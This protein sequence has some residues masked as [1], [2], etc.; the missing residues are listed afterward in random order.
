MALTTGARLGPYEVTPLLGAGGMGEVWRARDTRLNRDVALKFLLEVFLRDPERMARFEREAQLLA[1]LNHPNIAQ[2]YGLE[3]SG[4]ARA[5]VMEYVPGQILQG[6]LPVEEALPIAR[7]IAEALEYAHDRGIIHRDL[8]PS[9][10]KLTPEGN[11]KVLDFGLAKALDD[12]PSEGGLHNSPTLSV[13]GTRAG[14]ILGT[15]AYMSPE[16]AKGKPVD[17]RADIWS[18]GAVI[19]EILTGRQ[20]Y[21]G[22]TAAETLAAV[23]MKDP[24]LERLPAATPPAV[25]AMIRRCLEKDPRKRLQAIGEARL[26]LEDPPAQPLAP[27]PALT[28]PRPSGS[29]RLAWALGAAATLAAAALAFVHFRET[30]AETPPVR[31]QIS[32]PEKT[33]FRLIPS[34]SPDGRRV[35]FSAT[36]EGG[37]TRLWVRPLG[38]LE[39]QPLPGTDDAGY[40]FW[41]PDSRFI[42]FSAQGKL[43]KV[44]VSGGP[45]QTLCDAPPLVSGAWSRQGVIVFGSTRV[46]LFRVAAAGGAATPLTTLDPSR[47]EEGHHEPFFLPDDRHFLYFI[48]ARAAE[49]SGVYLGAVDARADSKDRRRLLG[50][51]SHAEYAPP[52]DGRLGHLLFVRE[53]TLMAQP[54]DARK[55]Q[56][57]GEPFP[58]AERVRAFVGHGSFSVSDTGVLAWREGASGLRAQLTWFDREGKKL[59]TAGKPGYYNNVA[60]SPDGRQAA[61]EHSP[62]ADRN[63]DIWL[64]DLIR[65]IPSRFTFHA[66]I[67]RLPV[68]SPDGGRIVFGSGRDGPLNL[69]EKTSNG[70]GNETALLQSNTAKYPHDWSRDGRFLVYS[71]QDPKTRLDL[72]VLP[73]TGDR[74]PA[75]YLQT[76]FDETQGQFSPD[77]KWMAYVSTESGV[78][79]V[80]VQ[81][82]PAAGGKRQ[83]SS[84]GGF[85]PRWRGDGKELFF[86]APGAVLMSAEIRAAPKFESSV[87]KRLFQTQMFGV[88]TLTFHRYA[89]APDGKRFL[90]IAATEDTAA[91]PITVV[92]NWLAAVKR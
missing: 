82:F 31:F 17:R 57:G 42:G 81:P 75:P 72:W 4:G 37:Q 46:P 5:L 16:Q 85:H 87:P 1:S 3:E 56:L 22:E 79:Q 20:L 21:T 43:K 10:V 58:V 61:A 83:I 13:A 48:R 90:M 23:M 52:L 18:F 45:P 60:L 19:Y 84:E 66:A 35:A 39:A 8:K 88:Q 38:S 54:F 27:T 9:N 15:A 47:Q 33:S 59:A 29:G 14:V 55:L 70:V 62:G 64:F 67:D 53:S 68:W 2:L 69:Y 30:P 77:G 73:M 12:S 86:L 44:E 65:D 32:A 41:S 28:E 80:Y 92:Q 89:V 49:H 71:N 76:E 40:H 25:R 63:S 91:A 34:I 24:A 36:A 11:V 78:P 51:D 26:I 74:K 6:P 7:Q 50:A